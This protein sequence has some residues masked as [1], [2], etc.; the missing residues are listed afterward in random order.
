MVKLVQYCKVKNKIKFK[1]RK[2]ENRWRNNETVTDFIFLGSRITAY[3]DCCHKS[4]SSFL[5]GR[6]AMI[7]LDSILK[8]R[9]ITLLTKIHVW[10][11]E[12]D[13]KEG[14]VLKNWCLQTVVMVKTLESPLDSKEIKPVNPKG[15]QPWIFIGRT[16]ADTE[17]PILWS[18]DMRSWLIGKVP[19]ARKVW[20]Q[21]EK[22]VTEAE[23]FGWHH[24]LYGPEFE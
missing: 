12:M 18:P 14:W 11:W 21:E 20:G 5:L 8:S 3:C 23:M 17:A 13:H 24:W 7:N 4:K 6:K 22:G 1:K 16:D 15:N 19:D 9:D 2:K 10:M